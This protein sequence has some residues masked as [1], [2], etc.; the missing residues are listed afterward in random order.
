MTLCNITLRDGYRKTTTIRRKN[1]T[2]LANKISTNNNNYN[3]YNKAWIFR[4][5]DNDSRGR[6]FAVD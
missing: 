5:F 2:L 6:R 1:T 3:I 4:D